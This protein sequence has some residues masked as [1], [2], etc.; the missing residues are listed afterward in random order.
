MKPIQKEIKLRQKPRKTQNN[1]TKNNKFSHC[2]QALSLCPLFLLCFACGKSV[3]LGSRPPTENLPN[4][5]SSSPKEPAENTRESNP[6]ST[7]PYP[8]KPGPSLPGPSV[9]GPGLPIPSAPDYWK[10]TQGQFGGIVPDVIL[11][12]EK[13]EKIYL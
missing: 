1:N 12:V 13:D 11:L 4:T 9:P 7:L 8:G 2:L 6:K 5:E 10:P 3:D